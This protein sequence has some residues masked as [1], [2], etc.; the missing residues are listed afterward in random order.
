MFYG[1][2]KTSGNS[3]LIGVVLSWTIYIMRIIFQYTGFVGVF[4]SGG[5][6]SLYSYLCHWQRRKIFNI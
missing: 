3:S 5:H 1:T 2:L 4:S 6:V